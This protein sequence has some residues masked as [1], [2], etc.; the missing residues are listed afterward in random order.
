VFIGGAAGRAGGGRESAAREDP[1]SQAGERFVG[2]RAGQGGS[3][4]RKAMKDRPHPLP[5]TRQAA[6]VQVSRGHRLLPAQAGGRG[7]FVAPAAHR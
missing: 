3:A 2:R 1:S 5:D 4:R 6:L 7:R